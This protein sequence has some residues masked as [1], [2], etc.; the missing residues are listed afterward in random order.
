MTFLGSL[1]LLR[2]LELLGK[3]KG[4]FQWAQTWNKVY[5]C[6]LVKHLSKL[7][8]IP[9]EGDEFSP[10]TREGEK[11]LCFRSNYLEHLREKSICLNL[12]WDL[13]SD[14]L[15]VC[16]LPCSHPCTSPRRKGNKHWIP[17]NCLPVVSA[18]AFPAAR[19][20]DLLSLV[21]RVSLLAPD[22]Y[23]CCFPGLSE[24]TCIWT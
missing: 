14:P 10:N 2:F 16:S 3:L 18:G 19:S 5:T 6:L 22:S 11:W 7:A 17:E 23:V 4:P 1:I 9:R 24:I 20:L 12:N 8:H 13:D 15:M 21:G